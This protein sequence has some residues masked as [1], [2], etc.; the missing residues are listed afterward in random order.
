MYNIF[1]SFWPWYVAGPLIGLLVPV[2]LI[3]FNKHFGVSSTFRDFC[4]AALP[5]KIDYFNYDVREH[6]WR[7]ILVLGAL[8]GGTIAVLI[9]GNPVQVHVSTETLADLNKLGISDFSGLIPNDIFSI[10]S[11]FTMKGMVFIVLGGF[12]VGFG[13]RWA[14]GCT[15]GHAITG[16]S[17]MAPSSMLAV[18]GFLAGGLV[19]THIILPLV[20]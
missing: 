6:L 11:L 1:Q 4:S 16:L 19:S 2:L 17:L 9:T 8:F 3:F 7:N 10:N 20:L 12:L 14:D 13:T 5:G 15:S 18:L